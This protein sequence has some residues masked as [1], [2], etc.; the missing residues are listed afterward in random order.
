MLKPSELRLA[1]DRW[2]LELVQTR[3]RRRS[4]ILRLLPHRWL[5]PVLEPTAKRLRTKL[6]T[7]LLVLGIPLL[8]ATFWLALQ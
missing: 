4:P 2:L 8:T 6:I 1:L 7:G 5:A 3:A